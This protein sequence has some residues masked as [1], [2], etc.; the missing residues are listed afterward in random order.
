MG[1]AE[2]EYWET[3]ISTEELEELALGGLQYMEKPG[4][5]L[6]LTLRMDKVLWNNRIKKRYRP[7][8]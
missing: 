1:F 8:V 3:E 7:V 2:S 5:I 4:V 6:A